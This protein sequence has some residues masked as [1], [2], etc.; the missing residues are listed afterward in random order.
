MQTTA[1]SFALAGVPAVQD[2]TVAAKLRAAGAVIL[3]KTNV[4]V[5]ELPLDTFEQRLVGARWPHAQSLLARSQR[6]RIQ[7]G[8]GRGGGLQLRGDLVRQ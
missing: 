2:S 3:G 1:G 4:R 6:V 5:G 7:F 8:I